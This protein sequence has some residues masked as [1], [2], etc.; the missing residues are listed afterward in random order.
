LLNLALLQGATLT[1][2]GNELLL[3]GND[4]TDSA[5][6]YTLTNEDWTWGPGK[7][8][9]SLPPPRKGHAATVSGM[10]LAMVGGLQLE[11]NSYLG[12]LWHMQKAS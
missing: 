8:G 10:Q 1:S 6:C 4:K 3:Y 9:T 11:D 5:I 7:Q 12:D 2:V